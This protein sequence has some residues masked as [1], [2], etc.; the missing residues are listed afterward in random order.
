MPNSRALDELN[1]VQQL[2]ADGRRVEA[3]V[4]LQNLVTKWP[5]D[6]AVLEALFDLLVQVRDIESA[7]NIAEDMA[8]IEPNNLR[9][10]LS[11]AAVLVQGARHAEALAVMLQALKLAPN[12]VDVHCELGRVYLDLR[13]TADAQRHF[14]RCEEL[15]P[16]FARRRAGEIRN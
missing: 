7:I 9:L 4:A 16:T 5:G 15:D 12:S 6:L 3:I 13:R 8:A 11:L 14:K 1:Q 2:L 10:Q